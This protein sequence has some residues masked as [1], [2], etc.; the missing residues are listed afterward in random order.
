MDTW[1]AEPCATVAGE[2][3][4]AVNDSWLNPVGPANVKFVVTGEEAD[5]PGDNA[6]TARPEA[7]TNAAATAATS[8]RARALKI[9]RSSGRPRCRRCE[10]IRLSPK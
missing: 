10:A 2:L 8:R 7:T 5:D 3:A 4:E 9:A 6:A 1:K